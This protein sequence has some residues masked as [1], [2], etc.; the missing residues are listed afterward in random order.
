MRR[1]FWSPSLVAVTAKE[2]PVLSAKQLP[3]EQSENAN[4]HFL[5]LEHLTL[6]QE[7]NRQLTFLKCNLIQI[8]YIYISVV[9]NSFA[10]GGRGNDLNTVWKSKE[11][12][13]RREKGKEAAPQ[14]S[15]LYL[16]A[17]NTP[18][19]SQSQNTALS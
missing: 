15:P 16:K 18:V 12:M 14:T 13:E 9:K 4:R 10:A 8:H 6:I 5:E 17:K 7:E 1:S 3:L 11:Q 19:V 2:H